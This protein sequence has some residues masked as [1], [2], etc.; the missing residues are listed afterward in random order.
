MFPL[1]AGGENGSPALARQTACSLFKY[2]GQPYATAAHRNAINHT[3]NPFSF[4]FWNEAHLQ[5]MLV[6][7]IGLKFN[8]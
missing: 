5:G 1:G 2:T 6:H 8:V 4:A 3:V 7:R